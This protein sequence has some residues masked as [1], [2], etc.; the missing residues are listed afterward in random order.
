MLY[1]FKNRKIQ[2]TSVALDR[3]R[4]VNHQI[5]KEWLRGIKV[6]FPVVLSYIP[7]GFLLGAQASM[8]NMSMLELGLMCAVNFA[9][10][11]EFVATGLWQDTPP[12]LLIVAMTLLVNCRHI[13]MGATMIPFCRR[14]SIK[15]IVLSFFFLCDECWALSLQDCYRRV[16]NGYSP[17]F[18]YK[19]YMAVGIS[20]YVT[21]VI[22]ALLGGYLGNMTGDLTKY[23]FDMAF[24]AIF[25]V[26]VRGM[27]QGWKRGVPWAI[28]L[29]TACL[30][31][32][33]VPGE[34]FVIAGTLAGILTVLVLP[35]SFL[36]KPANV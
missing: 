9:G 27:W 31:K 11:S 23:G 25:I 30:V 28:S 34:W 8:H 21:W 24:T 16:K 32:L 3:Q 14:F 18:S 29:V 26:I 17:A 13:L 2:N 10:G 15:R 36:K 6:V 19:F 22:S 1:R 35:E 4:R 12:L 7:F 20:L 33:T 5:R